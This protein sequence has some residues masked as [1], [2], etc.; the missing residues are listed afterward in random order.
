MIGTECFFSLFNDP[1]DA[2]PNQNINYSSAKI[3]ILEMAAL[4]LINV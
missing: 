1:N 3:R 4:A 2:L